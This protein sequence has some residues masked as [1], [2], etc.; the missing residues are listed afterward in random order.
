MSL[1]GKVNPNRFQAPSW[2]GKNLKHNLVN[3]VN[4]SYCALD[5]TKRFT[6]L[7]IGQWLGFL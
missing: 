2:S 6:L 4:E 1:S 7:K 5:E 3:A